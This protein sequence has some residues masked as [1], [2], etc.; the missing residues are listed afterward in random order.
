[1]GDPMELDFSPTR[2]MKRKAEDSTSILERQPKMQASSPSNCLTALL[3]RNHSNPQVAKCSKALGTPTPN[4]PH[5]G[6]L[7]KNLPVCPL[8]SQLTTPRSTDL[9]TL[10]PKL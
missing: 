9:P 7:P 6:N 8:V 3:T 4:P 10:L 2:G 1:M 5:F